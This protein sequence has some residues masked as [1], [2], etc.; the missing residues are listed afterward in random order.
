MKARR[1]LSTALLTGLLVSGAGP[2][3]AVLLN[4]W[5][6]QTSA[7]TNLGKTDSRV[8]KWV[9]TGDEIQANNNYYDLRYNSRGVYTNTDYWFNGQ[10]CYLSNVAVSGGGRNCTNGWYSDSL[11][12]DTSS[13]VSD[14]LN[15]WYTGGKYLKGNADSVRAGTKVCQK[16][17]VYDPD[18]CS[19]RRYAGFDY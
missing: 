5:F 6:V 11:D 16:E 18:A 13:V 9:Q 3:Q 15:K 14:G 4:F 2:A 8:Y 17:P 1:I 10:R 7:G 12:S 19:G